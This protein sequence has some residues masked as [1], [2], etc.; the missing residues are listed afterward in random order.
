MSH[1]KEYKCLKKQIGRKWMVAP[2]STFYCK[3]KIKVGFCLNTRKCLKN[4]TRGFHN[5][6]Q[7]ER[8]TCFYMSI[9]GNFERFQYFN[10][11]WTFWKTK[12]FSKKLEQ[13]FLVESTKFENAA[14]HTKLPCEKPILRQIE[15]GVPNGPIIKNGILPVTTLFS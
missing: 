2:F 9:K 15:R 13:N 12:I 3:I 4:G 6:P 1:I 7:F 8:S 10:F 5:S 14:F 11:E